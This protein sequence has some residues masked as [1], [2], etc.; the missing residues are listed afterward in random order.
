[1]VLESPALWM[2]KTHAMYTAAYIV[3]NHN[4][5][6]ALLQ[7]T[8][9]KP[10]NAVCVLGLGVYS[11]DPE[12]STK[13]IKPKHVEEGAILDVDGTAAGATM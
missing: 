13:L 2:D 8:R 3:I 5:D 10:W 6:P 11:Q 7:T 12:V 4:S 9:L 1:M